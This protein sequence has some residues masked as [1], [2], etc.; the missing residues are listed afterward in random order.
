MG[1]GCHVA[2]CERLQR[3]EEGLGSSA[4]AVVGGC[5]EPDLM[6]WEPYSG[7]PEESECFSALSYLSSHST[8]TFLYN[9]EMQ[10]LDIWIYNY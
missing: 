8:C 6:V 1:A 4:A 5:E 7:P 2:A 3:S 10:K 9:Q